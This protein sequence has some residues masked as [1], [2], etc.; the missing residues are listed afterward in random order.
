MERVI[1]QKDYW[2]IL[3]N[4]KKCGLDHGW[5]KIKNDILKPWN[6]IC[7]VCGNRFISKNMMEVDHVI[8]ICCGGKTISNNLQP[9]CYECHKKKTAMDFKIIN[10]LKNLN[11][12][13][14]KNTLWNSYVH[15]DKLAR[16]YLDFKRTYLIFKQKREVV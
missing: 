2:T 15:P 13:E 3:R 6:L 9:I 16:I 14:G 4:P 7:N 1:K 11:I 10:I 12:I 5:S 8:P